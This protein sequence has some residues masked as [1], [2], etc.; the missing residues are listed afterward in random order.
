MIKII[1]MYWKHVIRKRLMFLKRMML[2]SV[3]SL[4]F[5]SRT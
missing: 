4:M 1:M 2:V 3:L 5:L